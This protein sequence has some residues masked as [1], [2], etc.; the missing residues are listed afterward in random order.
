MWKEENIVDKSKVCPLCQLLTTAY[1]LSIG[2]NDED[3][4]LSKFT[5][6]F[7]GLPKKSG[8]REYNYIDKDQC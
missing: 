7:S 6:L 2:E 8:S 3:V 1:G 4:K 5:S